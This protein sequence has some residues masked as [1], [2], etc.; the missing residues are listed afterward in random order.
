MGYR[1]KH[2]STEESRKAKKHV[3][4]ISKSLIIMEMQIKRPFDVLPYINHK[5]RSKT[6]VTAHAGKNVEQG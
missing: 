5:L 2:F 6:Q 1:A 4:K 3:M